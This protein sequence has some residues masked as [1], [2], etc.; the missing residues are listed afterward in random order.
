MKGNMKYTFY[1]RKEVMEQRNIENR[2][3]FVALSVEVLVRLP[4]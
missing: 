1:D 3:K 2:R 4:Y